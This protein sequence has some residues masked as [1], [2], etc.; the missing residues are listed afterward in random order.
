MNPMA[1]FI[2]PDL[3]GVDSLGVINNNSHYAVGVQ[4]P[5]IMIEE[6]SQTNFPRVIHKISE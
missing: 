5:C 4:A 3:G 2:L 1:P 6:Q